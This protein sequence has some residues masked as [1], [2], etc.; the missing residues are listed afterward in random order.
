MC[1]YKDVTLK[2]KRVHFNTKEQMCVYFSDKREI[3]IPL[4]MIPTL[5]KLK[6][7]DREKYDIAFG[8]IIMFH[9]PNIDIS[10]KDL[11]NLSLQGDYLV[12]IEVEEYRKEH[13]QSPKGYI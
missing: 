9:V 12:N 5:K 2:I 6:P 8:Q 7:E 3:I 10:I 13:G 4:E 1:A 11:V